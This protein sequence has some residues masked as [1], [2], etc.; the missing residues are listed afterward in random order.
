MSIEK[1]KQQE[2][3][4]KKLKELERELWHEGAVVHR[5]SLKFVE[6]GIIALASVSPGMRELALKIDRPEGF[7]VK[8]IDEL[9]SQLLLVMKNGKP[10][11]EKYGGDKATKLNNDFVRFVF[12]EVEIKSEKQ[13]REFSHEIAGDPAKPT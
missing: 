8:D 5:N 12:E 6:D 4:D 13:F 9:R 10:G 2:I 7:E 11:F 3:I 1:A